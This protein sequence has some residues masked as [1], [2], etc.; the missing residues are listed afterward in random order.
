MVLDTTVSSL[1]PSLPP[2]FPSFFFLKHQL[3]GVTDA[4]NVDW[5][6][7]TMSPGRSA[8]PPVSSSWQAKM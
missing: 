6:L 5:A 3:L 2:F 8:N 7:V 4:C 1:S